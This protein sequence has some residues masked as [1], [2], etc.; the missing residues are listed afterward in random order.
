MSNDNL[1]NPNGEK[2]LPKK[3]LEII[4]EANRMSTEDIES[5]KIEVEFKTEGFKIESSK[6]CYKMDKN[7]VLRRVPCR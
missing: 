1:Q 3:I 6:K 2:D 4:A 5:L 7:G